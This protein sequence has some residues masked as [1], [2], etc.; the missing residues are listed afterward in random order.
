[1]TTTVGRP[2]EP[3][4]GI[5]LKIPDANANVVKHCEAA[6]GTSLIDPHCSTQPEF[7]GCARAILIVSLCTLFTYVY[8]HV[9]APSALID[10]LMASF[11]VRA[12]EVGALS[13]SFL[14]AYGAFQIPAG[15]LMDRYGGY[16][17]S[18]LGA[19]VAALGTVTFAMAT[20]LP[21]AIVGRFLVGFGST[22]A[23]IASIQIS[24]ALFPHSKAFTCGVV[25]SCG[26][27]GAGLAQGP[28][29]VASKMY[30]WRHVIGWTAVVPV[31]CS[32]PLLLAARL[33]ARKSDG[34][35]PADHGKRPAA[36]VR[37]VACSWW[38]WA[39]VC[40]GLSISGPRLAFMAAW[41]MPM[42]QA[43]HPQLAVGT[44]GAVV[45]CGYITMAIS[46]P[47]SGWYADKTGRHT[48]VLL[49]TACIS[50][51]L[52]CIII[53]FGRY[54]P[55]HVLAIFFAL[56]GANLGAMPLMFSVTKMWNPHDVAASANGF[57]NT[58]TVLLGIASLPLAG[59]VLDWMWD[60]T[61]TETD[62]RVYTAD[63]F[64]KAMP[65]FIL[66]GALASASSAVMHFYSA[67]I[68]ESS[69]SSMDNANK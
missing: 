11:D 63:A 21:V 64:S 47:L 2:R 19:L 46:G 69:K 65:L 68:R 61:E 57:V 9:A 38:N 1:M 5:S 42:A 8:V 14:Y 15:A 18:G 20:S 67:I 27:G 7:S 59:V 31:V 16:G 36:I 34:R 32:V 23:W 22:P 30:G 17:V 44:A 54:L 12:S 35:S 33:Q 66:Y 25:V 37:I 56:L 3:D 48:L 45:T 28:L 39:I 50:C 40:Y 13:G 58:F 52:L 49:V 6:K 62:R 4:S 53:V 60:G 55:V 41:A 51:G 29:A 24:A 10:H 26:M 43:Y